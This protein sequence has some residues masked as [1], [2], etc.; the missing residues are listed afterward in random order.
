M[1]E[2]STARADAVQMQAAPIVIDAGKVRKR[3]IRELKLGRG[4]LADEVHDAVAEVYANLRDETEGKEY[5]P[6]V[7]VYKQKRRRKDD[8]GGIFPLLGL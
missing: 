2:G 3:L 8:R 7:L 5:V 6:V 1:A 4:R